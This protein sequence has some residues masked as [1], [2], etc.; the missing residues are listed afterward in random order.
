MILTKEFKTRLMALK[1]AGKK[2]QYNQAWTVLGELES[3]AQVSKN[4]R[5]ESRIPNCYKYELPEGYRILFQ[6]V[7]GVENE[8]LALFVG[9]HDD[10]DHFLDTHKNWIFDPHRHTLKE[11]RWNTAAEEAVNSVRSPEMPEMKLDK[12]V[13]VAIEPVFSRLTDTQ[14][15]NAGIPAGDLPFVRSLN[16]PDSIEMMRFLERLPENTSNILLAYVTGSRSQREEIEAL[17]LNERE[18]VPALGTPQIPALIS[19]TDT[20]ISLKDLPEEKRAFEELPFEDWM[21]YL[22]PDQS[23]LV[24]KSFSG[25]ARLR[26]V[27]GSGKTVVAIHRARA[28]ARALVGAS[29]AKSVL[30]LTYNRSLC[31]LVGR[32]LQRLCTKQEFERI[33]VATLGK[34]CQEYIRFRSGGP[35][36]WRDEIVEQTWTSVLQ[37]YL[38]QLHQANFCMDIATTSAISKMDRDVQ[39]LSEEIDFIFGKFV[40]RDADS[41][42]TVERLG[43]GR[44]LGPNQRTL[45][46][47]MYK[48]LVSDLGAVRQ[49][50]AREQAR[51][52][53]SLLEEGE[54]PKTDYAA[55]V[56]DEIQDLSDIE[57]R[58]V[59]AI[60]ESASNLFLVGDGAQQIYKRGQSLKRIGIN[61][62]GRAF[63]LRKNYRNTTE[64]ISAAMALKNAQHI[65]RFDE[66]PDTSQLDAISS[67][68][69]GERPA[70]L[71]C[72]NLQKELELVVREIKYLTSRLGFS[73]AQ[74]CCVS[75]SVL[76]RDQ[77]LRHLASAGLKAIHYRADGVGDDDAVLISTLHSTKGHEF[78][79]VFILGLYEGVLPLYS[80]ADVEEI[81]RE[82]ALLYVAMTRAK[83]LLYLSYSIC[84]TH[85]KPL[86]ESRFLRDMWNCL[87]ILDFRPHPA[88]SPTS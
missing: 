55:V 52:A 39:F 30:F 48:N 31:E 28:A 46:L 79:S 57:L 45:I 25:P 4:F 27:S 60:G 35:V 13:Q 15:G 22:H 1:S 23:A 5:P 83:E 66:D 84:D 24:A 74:I 18:L 12:T 51:I 41:Y 40:H 73:P 80:A 37:R 62:S 36:T 19:C 29:S 6:R 50:D 7:E 32:L 75:R 82:A 70:L 20:F 34:W 61:V 54:Q 71:I 11:L 78:R 87:D 14:L 8:F 86:K 65:G 77:L 43:R 59:K 26:G 10:T 68:M 81:E 63:I 42:L 33:E 49:F 72:P 85:G 53:C 76:I 3:R 56:V 58:I 9:S 67:A 17:L 38:P 88:R 2:A 16:D 21:L 64:I 69:S 47:E 44:R